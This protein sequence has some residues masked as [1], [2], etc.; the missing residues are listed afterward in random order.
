M[1]KVVLLIIIAL[2]AALALGRWMAA[3]SGYVLIIR[4]SVSVDTTLGFVVLMALLGAVALV[5]GNEGHGVGADV[6][7]VCDGQVGIPQRGS[8]ESLNAAV[9]VG[10]LLY[11]AD[12][13]RREVAD[14]G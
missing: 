2:V 7:D 9:A 3:D 13:Q 6:I 11:E 8:V 14:D 1:K 10:I 5:V 12:R 4:D